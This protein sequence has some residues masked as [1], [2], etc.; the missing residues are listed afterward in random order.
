M[1]FQVIVVI[2]LLALSGLPGCRRSEPPPAA[3]PARVSAT[4][5]FERAFGPAPTTDKGTCFA[6]IIYF[7]S[8][9]NPGKMTPFPFFSF[10][11]ASLKKVALQRM[12]GG[13]DE[14][15]YRGEFLHLFPSGSR[16]LSLS[17][18]KGVVTVN[19]S[20]EVGQLALDPTRSELLQ[21]SVALTLGQFPGVSRVRIL[22]EGKDLLP[23]LALKDQP[24]TPVAEPGAP[25]LLGVVAMKE[26]A[27]EPIKE[28]D[29]LFDRPVEIKEFQ[30]SSD[31]GK[32]IAGDV[33]HTM[34]DM[35]AVLKPKDPEALKN[36]TSLRVRYRVVDKL[37]RPASGE[38]SVALTVRLHQ[39]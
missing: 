36:L 27:K 11:E 21:S 5:A 39:D 9:K 33:F 2:A 20:K 3:K 38:G 15:S 28:V 26:S 14:A 23:E 37:G 29:A 8:V 30:F 31:D 10:D 6:F 25:R 34:F 32:V 17:E 4:G 13:I 1:R 18:E 12:I 35:A 19:F 22:S 7:P 24:T 16:L